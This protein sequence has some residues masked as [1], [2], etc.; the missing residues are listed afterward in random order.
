MLKKKT[1]GIWP[2][3]SANSNISSFS[4]AI[5]YLHYNYF[6]YFEIHKD[7]ALSRFLL[8]CDVLRVF[9]SHSQWKCLFPQIIIVEI[10][11]EITLR[12]PWTILKGYDMYFVF[13]KMPSPKPRMLNI[14]T[15]NH[16]QEK[17]QSKPISRTVFLPSFLLD[18]LSFHLL[19]N[20]SLKTQGRWQLSASISHSL[21]TLTRVCHASGTTTNP[22]LSDSAGCWPPPP[23]SHCDIHTGCAHMVR[24][25][26]PRL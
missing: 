25:L 20:A 24:K 5:S 9:K 14:F 3:E 4:Q 13:P 15:G 11:W 1:I 12:N 7:G 6:N 19:L 2:L 21:S 10:F 8:I 22:R 26:I 23:H 18:Y 16:W 17:L